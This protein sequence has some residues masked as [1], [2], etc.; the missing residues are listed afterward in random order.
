MI[1]LQEEISILEKQIA[2][3]ELEL[4]EKKVNGEKAAEIKKFQATI[5]LRKVYL[6]TKKKER[7]EALIAK[8]RAEKEQEAELKEEIDVASIELALKNMNA[9]YIINTKSWHCIYVDGK[10]YQPFVKEIDHAQ[11]I[12][13]VW[14]D[15][16]QWVDTV[17]LKKIAHKIGRVHRDVERT[18]NNEKKDTFNQMN[19]LRELWLKPVFGEKNHIAFDT[20]VSNICGGDEAYT[21][22]L[23]KY[24]AYS[25]V[26][27]EDIYAPN[28]DSSAKGGSG[29]DTFFRILE[30]IFTEECCGEA[31]KETVQGTH[32]GELF[33]KIWVKVS[34][35]NNR[36]MNIEEL[37]NLTGG[38]NFRLRRMG[39]NAVQA[40][41]TF[42][43][44][45]MSNNYE[46]T[47]RLTGNGVV[48]EDRRWE[49]ICSNTSLLSRIREIEPD[50]IKSKDLLNQWQQEIY[51]NEEEIAKW[52]GN[53]IERHG[54]R[55][56][57]E[58]KTKSIDKLFA[59]HGRY[60]DDMVSRQKRS[61][62]IFMD[63]LVNL[64][65]ESNCYAMDKIYKIY[66]IVALGA[67][68]PSKEELGK[69]MVKWLSDKTGEEWELK[70]KS[71]YPFLTAS[72]D[73]RKRALMVKMKDPPGFEEQQVVDEL[74]GNGAFKLVFNIFDF[75]EDGH[76]DDK[77]NA[78]EDK[79]HMNNIKEDFL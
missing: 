17:K 20:L 16:D 65:D 34:E 60:Y 58:G 54:Y 11:M 48:S 28:V 40:P 30:I 38:G 39:E 6:E 69:R 53:I 5:D 32:N 76:F 23:E 42:R 29:R 46:G 51:I 15:S 33:G 64:T 12:D 50:D 78:L 73:D 59:L 19:E 37:K 8:K 68:I 14:Y 2:D 1:E 55:D 77:G 45:M 61:F 49:P 63:A 57:Y 47:A 66:R 18:F 43:F 13:H 75:I 21:A 79:P 10:R 74:K 22:Q 67:K 9:N 31:K 25:Y 27:P 72:T 41:R 26:C 7:D 24:I 3:L 70:T 36:I 52:L 62:D 44:F 71:Y 35:Q 56:Y 4:I